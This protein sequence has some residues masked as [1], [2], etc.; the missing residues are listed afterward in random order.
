MAVFDADFFDV[1]G[2]G[3]AGGSFGMDSIVMPCDIDTGEAFAG[4]ILCDGV[5]FFEGFFEVERVAFANVF[6]TKII[7]YQREHDGSPL[8]APQS[9][10]G[11]GFVVTVLLKTCFEEV[12]GKLAGLWQS[13]NSTKD[14][15]VNLSVA[16]EVVEVIFLDEFLRDVSELDPDIFGAVEGG[17]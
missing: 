13:I 11:S 14:G 16:G 8:V 10:C 4:P 6:Y 1:S 9:R 2:H 12:V 15:K 17:T 3:E 5:I 7:H